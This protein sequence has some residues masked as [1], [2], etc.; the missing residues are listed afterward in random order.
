MTDP[1]LAP[2]A[3]LEKAVTQNDLGFEQRMEKLMMEV[4]D[5]KFKAFETK[6]D[7]K[8]D[9]LLKT[10][11]IEMEQALRKGFGL[12]QDP[13]IHKSDL[14]AAI[15]K[16]ATENAEKERA[17]AATIK[18]GPDGNKPLDPFDEAFAKFEVKA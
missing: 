8:L 16:A 4:F 12:E 2:N 9:D 6:I 5:A 18:G 13:V 7:T 17:P 10:K 11:E 1:N 3:P 15:R 14:I